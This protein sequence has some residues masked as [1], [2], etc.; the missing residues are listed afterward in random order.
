MEFSKCFPIWNKL[1]TDEQS[2]LLNS[3]FVK[4]I[5]AGTVIH[6][7]NSDCM[8]LLLVY[9]G[10]LRAFIF[11]DEGKE[12]TI[13]RLFNFDMCLFSASCMMKNIQFNISVVAEKDTEAWVI[14]VDVYKIIFLLYS[15]SVILL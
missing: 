3:A 4:K 8:G 6:E 14:P 10:Q 1:N 15:T 11:S 13:Y 12:I 9:S 5:P 7:G 2:L